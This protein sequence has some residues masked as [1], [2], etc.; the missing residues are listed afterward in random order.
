M[1]AGEDA[2]APA[3]GDAED[4]EDARL[5]RE[6][7]GDG[8]GVPEEPAEPRARS[9]EDTGAMSFPPAVNAKECVWGGVIVEGGQRGTGKRVFGGLDRVAG[10][11]GEVIVDA[12]A[13]FNL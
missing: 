10:G 9:P 13:N 5:R 3:P 11:Q 2:A 12:H 7:A 8:G 4:W 6:A 1:E